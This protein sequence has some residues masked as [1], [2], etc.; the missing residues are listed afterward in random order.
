MK[1]VLHTEFTA[2]ANL[3]NELKIFE[4]NRLRIFRKDQTKF[5]KSDKIWIYDSENRLIILVER[6]GRLFK[7]G[8]KIIEQDIHP[9]IVKI[10]NNN[11]II[12]ENGIKIKI[13]YAKIGIFETYGKILFENKI[14][15]KIAQKHFNFTNTFTLKIEDSVTEYFNLILISFLIFEN[16]NANY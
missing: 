3:K 2:K 10:T 13:N 11:E 12:F 15:G 14:V 5:T 6:T 1:N 8:Y 9:K 7:D 4:N 16:A